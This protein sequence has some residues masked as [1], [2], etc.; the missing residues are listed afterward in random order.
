MPYQTERNDAPK[1]EKL[2][3]EHGDKID[4]ARI[5][6]ERIDGVVA[7]ARVSSLALAN[8]VL[9]RW[10]K[11]APEKGEG[12]CQIQ[13]IFD[14]GFQYQSHIGLSRSQKRISLARLLRQQLLT[15]ATPKTGQRKRKDAAGPISSITLPAIPLNAEVMLERYDI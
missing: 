2:V 6:I 12:Q 7:Q 3:I 4:I 15:M 13:I 10:A 9:E 1:D 8:A 14:D 11:D 5:L